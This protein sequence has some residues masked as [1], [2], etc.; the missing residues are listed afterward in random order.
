MS[1][2]AMMRTNNKAVCTKAYADIMLVVFMRMKNP[3]M[4]Q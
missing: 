1:V 2:P 3:Y 4:K